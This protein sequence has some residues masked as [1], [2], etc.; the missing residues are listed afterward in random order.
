MDGKIERIFMSMFAFFT[1]VILLF[2]VY[3]RRRRPEQ[4][5]VGVDPE[6]DVRENI[7]HYDE[8]GVGES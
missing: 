7:I 2:I 3:N 1:V 8:E 6:D 4:Y 5:V